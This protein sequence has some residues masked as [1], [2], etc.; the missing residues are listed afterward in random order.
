MIKR[1]IKIQMVTTAIFAVLFFFFSV[2]SV[3]TDG[4]NFFA[5]L[6][7]LFCTADVVRFI[8]LAYVYRKL[9]QSK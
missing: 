4:W 6:Y 8:K 7:T 2:Q 9:K 5:I 1:S 3:S